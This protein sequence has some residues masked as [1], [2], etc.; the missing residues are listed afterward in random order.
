MSQSRKTPRH[1]TFRGHRYVRA[2]AAGF[3]DLSEISFSGRNLQF[4]HRAGKVTTAHLL[5]EEVKGT[6]GM[7][8]QQAADLL[9]QLAGRRI[10]NVEIND[11]LVSIW[12]K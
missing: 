11:Q 12:I 1:I 6:L 3:D 7:G 5:L 2:A 8:R 9:R 10:Q 4:N